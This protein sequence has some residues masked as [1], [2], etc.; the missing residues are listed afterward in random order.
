[1]HAAQVAREAAQRVD[2][3]RG[4]EW[5]GEID[6]SSRVGG[7]G[8]HF[9]AVHMQASLRAEG[10]SRMGSMQMASFLKQD[11]MLASMS[12]NRAVKARRRR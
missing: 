9:R 4:Y 1:M 8:F 12:H 6:S 10:G 7:T 11:E 2:C 5:R 3:I